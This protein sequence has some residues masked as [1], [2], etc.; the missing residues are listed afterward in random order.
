MES[1]S[2]LAQ[3]E[4]SLTMD[5]VKEYAQLELTTIFKDAMILALVQPIC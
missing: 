3:S 5:I 4:P 2:K 1:V